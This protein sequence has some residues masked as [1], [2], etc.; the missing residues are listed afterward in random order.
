VTVEIERVPG[1][2]EAKHVGLELRWPDAAR[3]G[4]RPV[5]LS[6]WVYRGGQRGD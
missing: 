5:R 6:T 4:S 3:R 1:P 2:P